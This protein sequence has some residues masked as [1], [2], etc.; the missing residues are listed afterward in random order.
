MKTILYT[1]SIIL[2][3]ISVQSCS[4]KSLR[5]TRGNGVITEKVVLI[6]DYNEVSFRGP[7]NIVYE[8]KPDAE[9]YLRIET[10]ENIYALL[11][12]S[13]ENGVLSIEHK[14]NINPTKYNIVTNSSGLKDVRMS[15]SSKIHLKGKLEGQDLNFRVS[16]SGNVSG[17]EVI[18]KS[19]TSRVSG[20]GGIILAGKTETM[21]NTVS[22]SGKVDAINM[23]SDN[24]KCTVSGS[25]N[26]WV[27]ADKSLDGRVSGSGSIRYKGNPQTT[28]SI[29]GSGK[30]IKV[31]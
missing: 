6:S 8:Q 18:C 23:H 28:Q 10:D 11:T 12:I 16:G 20:S 3:A 14:E 30:M 24:V 22:G 27:Y 13:S 4:F 19:V 26:I 5:H 29:S 9:A 15:G 7:A 1:I 25:G 2:L 31:D 17:D 21:D